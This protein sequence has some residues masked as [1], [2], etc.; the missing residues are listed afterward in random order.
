MAGSDDDLLGQELAKGRREA[1]AA[2]YDRYAPRLFRTACALLDNSHDAEDVVQ[3]VF[4]GLVR[5]RASLA[6]ITNWQAYL[7]TALRH[8]AARLAAKRRQHRR[9]CQSIGEID[10][11]APPEDDR[12]AMEAA[13][14]EL[15]LLRLPEEQRQVIRLKTEAGLTFAEIADLLEIS[16]NTAA[17]R[18][19]YAIEK[20][21]KDLKGAADEPS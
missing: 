12:A 20:L 8:E 10:L 15:A 1:F 4:V 6:R 9:D 7:L 2:L 16:P 19:R 18:Y 21:R 13:L 11:T 14:L 3:A 5:S 17:S